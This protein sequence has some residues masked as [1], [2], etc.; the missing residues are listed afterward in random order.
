MLELKKIKRFPFFIIFSSSIFRWVF[1]YKTL[2]CFN[3]ID[4]RY[5]LPLEITIFHGRF[6]QYLI[7]W[8][9]DIS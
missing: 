4:P 2:T 9:G 1:F 6:G 7:I 8:D 5:L 3:T